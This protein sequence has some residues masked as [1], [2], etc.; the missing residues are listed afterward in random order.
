MD[1]LTGV[2][3]YAKN[4]D[5]RLPMA[6]CTK[7]MTALIV[8][9]RISDRTRYITVPAAAVGAP[10]ATIGLHAGDRI[11]VNTLLAGLLTR[12]ATDCA[13][14]LATAVAGNE[15]AFVVLMN[16]RADG[17]GL[18]NTRY[19]NASGIAAAR[20]YTSA[21]DL[22]DLSRIAMRRIAFRD[23]VR[24]TRATLRWQ[25]G[26]VLLVESHNVLNRL[27]D[28]VDGIKTGS[29]ELAWRC[30]ASS[31]EY[32]QRRFIV[33]TLREPTRGQETTD[34]VLLYHYG[35]SL[36]TERIVVAAGA[37]VT[38]VP[39]D[40]GGEV[41]L[42]AAKTLRAVVR[43]AASVKVRLRV[44]ASF[45][46]LPATGSIV[47]TATYWADGERLGAVQVLAAGQASPSASPQP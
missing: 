42:A 16:R 34:H 14:T 6:S 9:D 18:A 44:P 30:L 45:A 47:G 17:L 21:R 8:L 20:H 24:P 26:H 35:A 1:Q 40:G 27:Y 19:A 13:I 32:G 28:W 15:R 5:R 4:P 10:G 33:T 31:G 36:Y 7:I 38:R 12:S 22:A 37:E 43:N 3:V 25:P 2:I 46:S 11:T 23:L 41:V 39:L 29:S